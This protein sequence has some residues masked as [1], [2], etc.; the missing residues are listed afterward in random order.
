MCAAPRFDDGQGY[1]NCDHSDPVPIHLLLSSITSYRSLPWL[2]PPSH[3]L[4]M[5]GLDKVSPYLSL[6]MT[7]H[8]LEA[9]GVQYSAQHHP[10]KSDQSLKTARGQSRHPRPG[11]DLVLL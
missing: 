1:A 3:L 2:V 8:P 11:T 7:F 10:A 9:E 6:D 4:G 5:R